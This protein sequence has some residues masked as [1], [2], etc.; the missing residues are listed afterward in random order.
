MLPFD[1]AFLALPL[2]VAQLPPPESP[3]S[4]GWIVLALAAASMAYE[5]IT[6]GILNTRKLKGS[7]PEHDARYVSREEFNALKERTISVE[8]KQEVSQTTMSNELSAI[9]R[10]LGRIEGHLSALPAKVA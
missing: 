1:L 5:K 10:A 2:V 9:H 6:G 4:V 7:D 8:A 3:M